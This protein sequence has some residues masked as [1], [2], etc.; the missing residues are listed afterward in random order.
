MTGASRP[1]ILWLMSEDCSPHGAAY[2]DVLGRMPAIDRL[3]REGVLFEQA[4]CTAPVCA[5]S[6]FSLITGVHAASHGPAQH[7]RAVSPF[8]D[9]L[10]TYAELLREAGYY[11]TNNAK[12]DYNTDLDKDAVW[13]ESSATAHWRDRPDGAPFLA[14]FNP[15][16]THE[17][18]LFHEPVTTVSPEQVRVP[19]FLPDLPEIRADLARYYTAIEKVDRVFTR[20]LRELEED[21]LWEDTVVLYSS[22]HGGVGPRSKRFCYD[23]GLRVPLVVRVPARFAH[24]SPWRPGER[25]TTAV[26]HIDL[27]PTLLSL[28]DVRVP[29]SMQGRPLLGRAAEPPAGLAFGGRDRMG[30]RYDFVR[31]VR[32]ERYRYLRNY[33]PHRPY[34]QHVAYMWMARGYQAWE[35]A[36]LAGTLDE[37]TDRF[38]RP[39]PAEELYDLAEDPD[40]TH[41]LADD[42]RHAERLATLRD[43]LDAHLLRVNDNGFIPEGSPLQGYGPSREPGAYPL[44][45][46]MAL[47]A[48]AITRDPANLATFVT[49]LTDAHEVIRY[50]AAQGLLMLGADAAPA[51]TA[52]ETALDDP[53]AHVRIAAAEAYGLAVDGPRGVVVLAQALSPEHPPP[54]RLQAL[55]ALV[56]LGTDAA[57]AEDGLTAAADA[58]HPGVRSAARYLLLRLR[59]DY[60]PDTVVFDNDHFD[61]QHTGLV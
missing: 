33:A 27:A 20:L 54:I 15:M 32:D 22:D 10:D 3:A 61:A 7:M 50:W 42:P 18:A 6:R 34:G 52:L 4:F 29:A 48:T 13:D 49:A 2:G 12:T 59:G 35:A 53:S 39:K 51:A 28:A 46:V 45:E 44:R 21:G 16:D 56:Y 14:V 36:H 30:E 60:T 55:N 26:S 47:A 17:S 41:N 19:E 43:L 9:A 31:T 58:D 57:L 37:P 8:P 40:E 1:N 38:F 5:P 24:L 11:C 23:E 25:V